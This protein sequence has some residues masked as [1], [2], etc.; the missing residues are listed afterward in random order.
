M[1]F[2][3]NFIFLCEN[4][5][6]KPNTV[7]KEL[8]IGSSIITQWK[9]GSVPSIEKVLLLADYF[10]VSADFLLGR[11]TNPASSTGNNILGNSNNGNNSISVAGLSEETQDSFIAEFLKRFEKLD[12]DDKLEIMNLTAQKFKKSA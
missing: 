4:I 5:G 3:D 7:G 6:K 8:N 11:T 2:Y 12:F 1:A 10:N 9:N